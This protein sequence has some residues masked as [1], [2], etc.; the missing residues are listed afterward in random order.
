MTVDAWSQPPAEIGF[1]WQMAREADTLTIRYTVE[2]RGAETLWLADRMVQTNQGSAKLLD[3]PIV[4]TSGRPKTALVA[5]GLV[6]PDVT[7]MFLQP[8]TY[9]AVAAGASSQ[10]VV[11]VALPLT[12]W[13]PAGKVDPLEEPEAV[14]FALDGFFGEPLAWKDQKDGEG[15]AYRFPQYRSR[16]WIWSDAKPL[17]P[18]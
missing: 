7:M 11:T 4:R 16:H 10:G 13:H 5:L 2:N 6:S 3:R 1:D 12:S 14:V 18:G 15:N 9:R 17:P 8:P